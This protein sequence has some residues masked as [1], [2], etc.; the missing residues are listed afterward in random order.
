M[1]Y[2]QHLVFS[3]AVFCCCLVCLHNIGGHPNIGGYF[4]CSSCILSP[5]LLRGIRAVRR[6]QPIDTIRLTLGDDHFNRKGESA[7][8]GCGFELHLQRM[9]ESLAIGLDPKASRTQLVV[10]TLE[11]TREPPSGTHKIPMYLAYDAVT[12]QN[13]TPFHLTKTDITISSSWQLLNVREPSSQFQLYWPASR[14][15][16]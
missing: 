4:C 3:L 12:T 10:F 1:L 11:S 5:V 16:P 8:L 14:P 6:L 13:H 2:L 15:R 9:A 7:T